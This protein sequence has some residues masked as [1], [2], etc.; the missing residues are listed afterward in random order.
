MQEQTSRR[1]ISVLQE[2]LQSKEDLLAEFQK[3]LLQKERD[4]EKVR[5]KDGKNCRNQ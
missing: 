5:T 1:E 3:S 2:Q 4:L